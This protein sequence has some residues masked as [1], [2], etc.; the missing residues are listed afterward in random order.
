M[1]GQLYEIREMGCVAEEMLS[2]FYISVFLSRR[3]TLGKSFQKHPGKHK[4]VE[5]ILCVQ[6]EKNVASV[7]D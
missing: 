1:K 4:Y 2:S 3:L 5:T 7:L 6:V